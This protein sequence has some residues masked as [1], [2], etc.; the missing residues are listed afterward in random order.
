[1]SK[2]FKDFNIKNFI[3]DN[4]EREEK[5]DPTEIQEAAIPKILDGEDV[6]GKA[7]TGTGKTL[8]YLIP[9]IEK[10][11]PEKKELQML[12]LAPSRELSL[13]INRE[14]ESVI[15][16]TNISSVT[17]L[18]GMEINRQLDKLKDKPQIIVA[19]PGRLL[20]IIGLK[21]LK[22]HG[23]KIIALDEV[24]QILEQGFREKVHSIIDSTLKDRQVVSFSATLSKDALDILN[25][26]MKDPKYISLDNA[27]PV[28]TGIKHFHIVSTAPKKTETLSELIEVLKPTKSLVFIN[29][30]ENVD[31][32]VKELKSYG[33]SVGGIQ[34]RTN[35]QDRQHILTTFNNGK[36]K[37]LVTTDL[38]TRGMD[39]S[40]VSHIFNMDLP[41]NP[42]DYLHRAGRTGRMNKKGQV[43]NIVRDREKFIMFKMM[44]KLN[45]DVVEISI[46]NGKIKVVEDIIN[47]KKESI[48]KKTLSNKKYSTDSKKL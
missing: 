30:N 23:V 40:D 16:G 39:F 31:R 45:I 29:K 3:V 37:I 4:L 17:I 44:K 10:I 21:K 47:R 8:A 46:I 48:Y 19:T 15:K 43:Y 5:I 28:P 1:M 14:I 13:Q 32:F 7:K 34:T 11:D 12:V 2:K 24:D 35:N 27:K 18:E 33:L 20:H 41:L 22:V 6:I 36:L 25:S 26:I 38:F 9:M 42:V